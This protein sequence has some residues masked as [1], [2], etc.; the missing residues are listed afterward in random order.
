MTCTTGFP[1]CFTA[2]PEVLP[3]I[4]PD[5]LLCCLTF[6]LRWLQLVMMV[7]P[8]LTKVASTMLNTSIISGFLQ[9]VVT[10]VPFL[11]EMASTM[12]SIPVFPVFDLGIYTFNNILCI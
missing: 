7:V 6:L 3:E 4:L 11:P 9:L 12:I 1:G 2:L 10:V 8:F 5:F